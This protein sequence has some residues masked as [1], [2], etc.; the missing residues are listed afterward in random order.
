MTRLSPNEFDHLV[1]ERQEMILSDG[2][3]ERMEYIYNSLGSRV[4][5]I[6][7]ILPSQDILCGDHCLRSDSNFL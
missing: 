6:E 2:D 1:L 7:F 5:L 4:I 3:R